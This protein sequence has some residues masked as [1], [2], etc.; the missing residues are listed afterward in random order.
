MK[1]V[2]VR[3]IKRADPN[4]IG[5]LAA[6]GVSTAHEAYGRYGL[7]KPYLRP[8]WA[9]RRDRRPRGH[10]AGAAGRQLDAPCRG[11][12]MPKG[13]RRRRRLH[14]RQHRRHVR[15]TAGDLICRAR[16]QRSHPRCRLP[17]REGPARDGFPCLVQGGFGQGHGEG[18]ARRGQH[19]GGV[20]RRQCRARRRGGGRRRRRRG[21]SEEE[22]VAVA[23]KA[24][25]RK[26][27]EE[28]KRK[29]LASGMLGL[30]M[31]KM[32]EGLEKAGLRYV[33]NPEDI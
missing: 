7:M 22:A 29:Q 2:V 14:S 20:Q 28:G 16:R 15:R 26:E 17:R 12:A 18:D 3:N 32:R 5:T 11:R 1:P 33:D 4:A 21:D 31:Y 8:I 19:S 10:H 27:D 9:G 30:D 23:A 6:C 25:K 13:R 24:Q